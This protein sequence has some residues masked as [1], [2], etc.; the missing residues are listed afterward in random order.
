MP[1]T[2]GIAIVASHLCITVTNFSQQE[3]SYCCNRIIFFFQRLSIQFKDCDQKKPCN[4]TFQHSFQPARA[5]RD[6]LISNFRVSL[7]SINESDRRRANG[8]AAD[9]ATGRARLTREFVFVASCRARRRHTRAHL[10][11]RADPIAYG[12]RAIRF[13]SMRAR[14]S[15]SLYGTLVPLSIRL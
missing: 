13:I 10:S 6:S 14:A 3:N 5:S 9:G 12:A 7:V 8:T 2:H 11:P 1:K 4:D 15:L